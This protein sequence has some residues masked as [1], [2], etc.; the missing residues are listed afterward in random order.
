MGDKLCRKPS[1]CIHW[2]L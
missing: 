2:S 1:E